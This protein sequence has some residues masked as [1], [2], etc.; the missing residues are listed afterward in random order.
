MKI[1][2]VELNRNCEVLVYVNALSQVTK[3]PIFHED[4]ATYW[5]G[6]NEDGFVEFG[7][8]HDYPCFGHEAGYM[9]S[10]RSGVFNGMFNKC[11]MSII[12]CVDVGNGCTHKYG[13][14]IVVDKISGL[15]PHGYCIKKHEDG[16]GEIYY[17]IHHIA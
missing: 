4:G 12:L 10:S 1:N 13:A 11:C 3:Q 17:R 14:H 8:S 7:V 15:L 5:Y 6:E 2:K 16:D 9:W